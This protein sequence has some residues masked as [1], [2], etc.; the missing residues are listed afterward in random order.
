MVD[1]QQYIES[2]STSQVCLRVCS[3]FVAEDWYGS[4]MKCALNWW[5][6]EIKVDKSCTGIA[7]FA[8]LKTSL[9]LHRVAA[10]LASVAAVSIPFPGGEIKQACFFGNVCYGGYRNSNEVSTWHV[11]WNI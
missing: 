1:V 2:A 9:H 10:V 4:E 3:P 7:I 8:T 5:I 6:Y 11:C